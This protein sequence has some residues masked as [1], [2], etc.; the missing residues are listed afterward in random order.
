MRWR[1]RLLC[2][3]DLL[4]SLPIYIYIYIYIYKERE[5]ERERERGAK[6]RENSIG[7]YN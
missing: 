4:N 3:Q 5:R 7:L 1:V 2:I 6:L